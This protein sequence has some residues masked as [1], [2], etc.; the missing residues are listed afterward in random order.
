MKLRA[1]A[2]VL[3]VMT[4]FSGLVYEITWQR[5]L[6]T[7]LGSHSEATAAVLGIF[8][9]GLALGYSLFGALTR[10]LEIARVSNPKVPHLLAVYGTLELAIGVY[11]AFFPLLFRGI[12]A[13]SL[14][15]PI[16]G[17][18]L[19]F[20][21]DVLLSALL[22]GP[23]AVLMGGTIPIL[24]QALSRDLDDAT[25]FHALVYGLN[26][27]G[28]FAGAL[29]AGYWLIPRFGL[30][31]ILLMMAAIN[32]LAGSI[33]IS[34][35]SWNPLSASTTP[36]ADSASDN[37]V[38]VEG[39]SIYI[40]V[41]LLC[42]FAMMTI[43]TVLIRIGGLSFGSSG[44]TFSMVVAV[45]VLSIAIGSLA[46]SL[47]GRIPRAWIVANQWALFLFLFLL[48]FG[49]QDGP[50]WAHALR[51]LFRDQPAGFYPYYLSAF[52]GVLLAIGLPVALSGATLPLIFDH[53]RNQIED[54]GGAAGSLYS[55][56][57]LGSLLGALIG[58]YALFFWLDLHQVYRVALIALAVGASATTV[59]I[60]R[61]SR[62]VIAPVLLA[63]ALAGVFL[64]PEWD[65][66]RLSAGLFR[67]REPT[68]DTFRGPDV[69]FGRRA[70]VA[71]ALDMRIL[72]YRD[73]PTASVAMNQMKIFGTQAW[74][75]NI[76]TNGK[77]DGAVPGDYV[78]MAFATLLPALLAERSERAFVIGYGTGVSVGEFAALESTKQVVVA[79]ISSGVIDAA[80][81]FDPLNR[82]ASVNPKVE[83][84]RS[85]A[86]RALLRSEGRFDVISSE[87]SNPWVAGVEML[88]S[89]EFL[90]AARA[91]LN[92]GGV[93][94]QWFHGYDTNDETIQLV[95]STYRSVFE[96]VAVWGATKHDFLILGMLDPEAA[97]D[98]ERLK[99]R[100]QRPDMAAGLA[101][102][103][104]DSFPELLA[105]EILPTGAIHDARLPPAIHTL[106]HPRLSHVAARAFFAPTEGADMPVAAGSATG[107]RSSLV[108]R[109]LG[110]RGNWPSEAQR[111]AFAKETCLTRER[112]CG[113][114]LAEWA[115]DDPDSVLLR[116][117]IAEYL[118]SDSE[119]S[120]ELIDEMAVLFSPQP[121]RLVGAEAI[122]AARRATTLF[123]TRFHYGA[124]FSLEALAAL[125][126]RC[127]IE[128]AYADRC[129]RERA[130]SLRRI[131]R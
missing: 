127:E 56:N 72:F 46:V 13:V 118:E 117:L 102:C 88:F 40:V 12:Q 91:K 104:I 90:E 65:R 100:F 106:L 49:L 38:H 16:A 82:G 115:H 31:G 57:T 36:E 25:R 7:L 32:V 68:R 63:V 123:A 22:I 51:A 110:V 53:L 125:W 79:E 98:V 43:Q 128:P 2:L 30:V 113:A 94:A 116:S 129:R 26:T 50:Y 99:T 83:I 107:M 9:G 34:L 3:T 67:M 92:P 24:T 101:R 86:Y 111:L 81:L 93:Y 85:D 52:A 23:P 70:E 55:W 122:I 109:Y 120:R 66:L 35:A 33:F 108:Q 97:R 48:Y 64:L 47:A 96:H 21:A 27:V 18:G 112:E 76:M 29:A 14:W 4:G 5:Y 19:N 62:V 59:V 54:L 103:G 20:A 87:P 8:L 71:Q 45:F 17:G 131:G 124:P 75:Y 74:Q 11:A 105:H 95:L 78:T 37:P 121:S 80:P 130:S 15:I 39:Y 42:G 89:V 41:A 1:I 60:F 126:Q 44:F 69:F 77:S 10:R 61:Q 114:I 6:A 73:D 58:G 119:T 28:A 84:I